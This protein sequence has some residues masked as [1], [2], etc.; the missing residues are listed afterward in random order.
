MI[1][2]ISWV[3]LLVGLVSIV[4]A[5]FAIVL[6]SKS[7][8]NV[9]NNLNDTKELLKLFESETKQYENRMQYFLTEMDKKTER[10]EEISKVTRD[11]V[12][13]TIKRV[14]DSQF[15]NQDEAFRNQMMASLMSNPKVLTELTQ[16]F[17]DLQKLADQFKDK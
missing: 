17:P 7:E 9:L 3:S 14:F 15:P 2:V 16:S 5:L 1:E 10:I 13:D 6:S 8:K 12:H 11:D 4:V